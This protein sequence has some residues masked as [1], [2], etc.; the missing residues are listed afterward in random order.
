MSQKVSIR[1]KLG[2]TFK[3]EIIMK[4]YAKI[5]ECLFKNPSN[6]S[7]LAQLTFLGHPVGKI[8]FD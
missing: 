3:N 6:Y 1:L 8:F 4:F 2:K 5:E 7:Q